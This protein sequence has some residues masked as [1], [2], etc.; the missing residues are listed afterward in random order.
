MGT[1][2]NNVTV[3]FLANFHDSLKSL[4][5]FHGFMN[6]YSLE[7]ILGH[8]FFKT[9]FSQF[10]KKQG[11]RQFISTAAA[12]RIYSDQREF[13]HMQ[14]E[15]LAIKPPCHL[16]SNFKCVFGLWRKIGWNKDFFHGESL[17]MI[18]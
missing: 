12:H 7:I 8:Q 10:H 1:H 2:N 13:Q 15:D 6:F 5:K 16:N 9:F 3:V 4:V 17:K 18:E 14:Q 11:S